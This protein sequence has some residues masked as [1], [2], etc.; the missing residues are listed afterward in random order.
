MNYPQQQQQQKP[1]NNQVATNETA[2]NITQDQKAAMFR[3]EEWSQKWGLPVS[4]VPNMKLAAFYS[5]A[6][7]MIPQRFVGKAP[8]I[9]VAIKIAEKLRCDPLDVM[10]GIYM[11]NGTPGWKTD[12]LI[13]LA[14]RGNFIKTIDYQVETIDGDMS[15]RAV[16]T[17]FDDKAKYGT[18]VSMAM[19]KAEGWTKNKKYQT[20]PELM[21]KKRAASFLI[22]EQFPEIT[23]GY[24][25]SEEHEDISGVYSVQA[26]DYQEDSVET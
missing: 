5:K 23:C 16:A 17:T 9:Y 22:R 3:A 25:T 12:F 18:A 1:I 4:E 26:E 6:E 11:V 2:Q 13:A 7:G 14:K 15:V 19:A 8:S 24:L 10:N 21:L 20:M